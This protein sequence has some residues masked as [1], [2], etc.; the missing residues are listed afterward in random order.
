MRLCTEMPDSRQGQLVLGI[1]GVRGLPNGKK[2]RDIVMLPCSQTL[3][4]PVSFPGSLR[5]GE[6][7]SGIETAQFFLTHWSSISSI[8]TW[9]PIGTAH[10][11]G[12]GGGGRGK[13]R[14][15]GEGEGKGGG[16][17]GRDTVR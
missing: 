16:G 3:S 9:N 5:I 10:T 13:G 15:E 6:R 14:G 12:G 1:L 2:M 17:G 4:H 8:R 7:K 11:L